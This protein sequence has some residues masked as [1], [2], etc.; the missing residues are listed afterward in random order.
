[1]K[2]PGL[3]ALKIL[4]SAG[5]VGFLL[6][7]VDLGE[8]GAVLAHANLRL[9]LAAAAVAHADRVLQG[10]KWWL[11]LRAAGARFGLGAAIANT[12]SGN[13]AGMFLP[14]GVGGDFVRV[15]LLR[16]SGIPLSEVVAS[17]VVERVFGVLA[18]FFTAA[19]ATLLAERAGLP[20]PDGVAP[21]AVASLVV[22]L[23]VIALSF[24]FGIEG[25]LR[26]VA[27]IGSRLRLGERLTALT[28]S[29][30]RYGK[31]KPAILT[32]F[33][34]SVAEVLMVAFVFALTAWALGIRIPLL[35]MAIIAPVTLFIQRIPIT[36][37][38]LGVQEGVLAG[39]LVPF[40]FSL[41]EALALGVALRVLEAFTILP[42]AFLWL[43]RRRARAPEASEGGPGGHR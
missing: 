41:N 14:S 31:R 7:R 16:D 21:L 34:L 28:D 29:Y 2:R 15:A 20:V 17:I 24:R 18:L 37:N 40:G 35:A 1:M 23:G 19:G 4:V 3:G 42:G 5:L 22:L 12:Y 25:F 36:I 32:Y 10:G 38:G 30:R 27:R 33:V 11:L 39:L 9:A 26:W 8:L 6:W 13:F 43:A